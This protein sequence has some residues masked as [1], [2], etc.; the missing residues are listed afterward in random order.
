MSLPR[1]EILAT[2]GT[3][4]GT[5]DSATGSSYHSGELTGEALLASVPGLDRIAEIAVRQIA[6]IPSQDMNE[7]V[8][9]ALARA[10]E[11]DH[12]K[13]DGFVVTHGTDTMEE[14]SFFLDLV[15]PAGK[16]VVLTGAMLPSTAISADGPRNIFNAV[17]TA[18]C[19]ASASYGVLVA[20]N[21][22]LF[23]ARGLF[24]SHATSLATFRSRLS[25]AIGWTQNA[26]VH[27]TAA[28]ASRQALPLL[29]AGDLRR[30]ASLP[31]V[32]VIAT[33][34]GVDGTAAAAFIKAGYQ[35]LVIEGMGDGNIPSGLLS[36]ADAAV[37]SG[38]ALVRSSR[39]PFGAV[40]A[41][42]EI[43]DQAHGFICSGSLSPVQ[44]RILLQIAL[45]ASPQ[46]GREQLQ[47]LFNRF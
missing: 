16:P 4:A 14:T 36:A 23:T 33:W 31:R 45:L 41:A 9:L 38:M 22:E 2:G 30:I 3:I 28:P 34:A 42:G 24:K 37:A 20:M 10:I 44:S 46:A 39:S 40:L 15:L 6:N 17:C 21:S 32:A 11:E 13:F 35:G 8:W 26:E 5:G 29:K 47:A 19:P 1:I 18:A 43:N 7:A 27:F 12:E 25:G